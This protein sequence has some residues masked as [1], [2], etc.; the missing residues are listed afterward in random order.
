MK[1]RSGFTL[2]ELVV[3]LAIIG[4]LAAVSVPRL[5]GDAPDNPA[6]IGTSEVVSLLRQARTRALSGAQPVAL[7]IAP[8]NA[9]YELTTEQ[10]DSV[11]EVTRGVIALPHGI[12]LAPSKPSALFRFAASG[13]ALGDTLLLRG[14]GPVV[15][16]WVDRWTGAP[17]VRP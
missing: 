17:H 1:P 8:S 10:G 6:A 2:L 7:R 4:V 5:T 16:I 14:E 15:A 13:T 12:T 11:A 3:V 9:S